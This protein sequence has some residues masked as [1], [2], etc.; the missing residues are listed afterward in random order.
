[1]GRSESKESEKRKRNNSSN[2]KSRIEYKD[3]GDKYD[4]HRQRRTS[5]TVSSSHFR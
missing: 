2:S 5:E 3:G 4:H 1:M